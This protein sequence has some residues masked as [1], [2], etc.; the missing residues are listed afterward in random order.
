M[1]FYLNDLRRELSI[2]NYSYK[3][4]KSYTSALQKYLEFV[5]N[6]VFGKI[7]GNIENDVKDFLLYQKERDIAPKTLNTYLSA[8]KFFYRHTIRIPQ[9]LNIKF[10]KRRRRL[11]VVLSRE[12][13]WG[14]I[15]HLQNF[16]HRLLLSLAYGSGLRVSEV[17][18]LQVRD[19][20][21][22]RDIIQIRNSKNGS[23]RQTI[24]P[25]KISKDLED[26]CFDREKDEPL[27]KSLRGG[28]LSVRTLQKIFKTAAR[29]VGITEQASFH[30]LRHSFASHLLENGVNLRYIQQL[31]G[32]KSIRTTQIYT[33]VT[34]DKML[35]RV[36]SPL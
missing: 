22:R 20:D 6:D 10:S 13:V 16:K 2:R 15:R 26:W 33:R 14:I 32:H 36:K 4:L 18:D 23:D 19:L 11:P 3:T 17:V 12:E 5:Q 27:F 35:K 24:V 29:K 7:D 25:E 28:K 8:I 1:F 21:F 9:E 30:S 34:P 31:L